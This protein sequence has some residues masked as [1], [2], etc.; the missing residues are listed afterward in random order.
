ML[1]GYARGQSKQAVKEEPASGGAAVNPFALLAG[2]DEAGAAEL[3]PPATDAPKRTP[4]KLAPRTVEAPTADDA[5]EAEAP[6]EGDEPEEGEVAESG[7]MDEATKRSID[8]SLKEFLAV[9]DI[10]EG[11]ATFESLAQAHRG[12]LAKAFIAKVVDGKQVDITATTELFKAVAEAELLPEPSFRDAFVPTVTD[13][14]DIATDA[15]KAFNTIGQLMV[16]AQL[17]DADVQHLQEQ[18]V[19]NDDD[20]EGCQK[21][22]M[23][24]HKAASS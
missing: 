18:M 6:G 19:S 15:P 7:K 4:L 9:R 16:A 11:K 5:P 10:E 8:N 21:R 24:A 22:L 1:P 14:E 2:G 13:L 3:S 17:S 23:D 12:E 20:L